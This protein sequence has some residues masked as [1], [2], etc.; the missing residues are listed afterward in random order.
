MV[1]IVERGISVLR[2]E[3]WRVFVRRASS[4]LLK[5]AYDFSGLEYVLAPFIARKLRRLAEDISDVQRAVDFA[6][7]FKCLGVSIKPSQVK[8]EIAELLEIVRRVRPKVVLEIGTA[9]GEL[10]S[11]SRGWLS[12]MPPS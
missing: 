5:K 7:S 6:S 2:K 3:G 12:R 1:E 11:C 4:Y 10:S 8:P 9:A